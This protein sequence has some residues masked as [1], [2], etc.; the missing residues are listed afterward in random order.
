MQNT[1]TILQIT[2]FSICAGIIFFVFISLFFRPAMRRSIF[3]FPENLTGKIRS[4]IRYLPKTRT[5]DDR[6]SLYVNELLLGPT[7]PE[8]K[9]LYNINVRVL[10]S[11]IRNSTSYIDLSPLALEI[12]TEGIPSFEAFSLFKKNVFTNFRNV[13]NIYMYINGLEVYSGN[14]GADAEQN[15]KKR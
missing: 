11:F 12:G 2:A 3:F 15:I 6:F 10:R 5:L 13:D 8:F 9:P 4:E 7:V 1:H 14:T